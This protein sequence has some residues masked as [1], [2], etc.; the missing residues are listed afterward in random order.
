MEQID[1]VEAV[2]E[3]GM[4]VGRR[5]WIDRSRRR[6]SKCRGSPV[7]LMCKGS[8]VGNPGKEVGWSAHVP[9]SAFHSSSFREAKTHW[10]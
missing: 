2:V 1:G 7:D 3:A 5:A 6:G 8:T 9:D 4:A 10:R